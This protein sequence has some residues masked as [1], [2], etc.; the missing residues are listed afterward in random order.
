MSIDVTINS[1]QIFSK[2]QEKFSLN[3]NNPFD[4]LNNIPNLN[5]KTYRTLP[6]EVRA[7]VPDNVFCFVEFDKQ[8]KTTLFYKDF[9]INQPIDEELLET[10]WN[11]TIFLLIKEYEPF[12]IDVLSPHIK[13]QL[14]SMIPFKPIKKLLI[15]KE[16]EEAFQMSNIS[17]LEILLFKISNYR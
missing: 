10:L 15:N 2:L 3:S 8:N 13:E 12:I 17:S 7:I 9:D 5:K 11:A 4:I 14:S 6:A 16:F 1:F